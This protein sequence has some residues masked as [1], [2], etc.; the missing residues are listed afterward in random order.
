VISG[1]TAAALKAGDD[2]RQISRELG[3]GFVLKGSV[4]RAAAQVR[5]N[6]QLIQGATGAQIWSEIFDGDSADIFALQDRITGTIA[7]STGREISAALARDGEVRNTNPKSWDFVMRG[8]AEEMKPQSL[9]SLRTQ[10]Q[11]FGQAVRLDPSNCDAQARLARTVLLQSTQLHNSA[12]TKEDALRRGAAAAEKAVALDPNNPLTHLAMTYVHVL[13]GDFEQAALAAEKAIQLDRNLARAHNMLANALVHLGRGREAVP[14]SEKALH[15]DPRG[16]NLP[17]FLTI[18]GFS[19]LQLVQFDEAIAC[20][21]RARAENPKLARAHVGAAIT[22]ASNGDI[23]GAR[24][25]AAEL[26]A[27]VPNYRLSQT[28]DGCVPASPLAYRQFYDEILRP[29]AEQAGVPV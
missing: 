1:A 18:L 9:E 7:N 6:A 24:R 29:G 11:L 25:A 23:D 17:E 28:I 16:P 19:R 20:F 21:A 8:I 14:A 4:Q 27:L 26:L 13:R 2:V 22:L 10:E 3:V 12:Q 5:I 15:L